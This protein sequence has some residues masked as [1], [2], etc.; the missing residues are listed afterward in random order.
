MSDFGPASGNGQLNES[1]PASVVFLEVH[2][3][4]PVTSA[5]SSGVP[6]GLSG[7][8]SGLNNLGPGD[9][10][11]SNSTAYGTVSSGSAVAP[12]FINLSNSLVPNTLGRI[13]NPG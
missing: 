13:K 11:G 10:A 12:I 8:A 5:I 1:S 7:N 3:Q 6:G 9:T 2:T 4:G